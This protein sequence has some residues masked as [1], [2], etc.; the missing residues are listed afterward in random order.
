MKLFSSFFLSSSL[1][2]LGAG[3]AELKPSFDDSFSHPPEITITESGT[4][5][6]GLEGS[7]CFEG[8]CVDM[9]SPMEIMKEENRSFEDIGT[10]LITMNLKIIPTEISIDL[11]SDAMVPVCTMTSTKVTEKEYTTKLCTSNPGTYILTIGAWFA[12][13]DESYSF[14]IRMKE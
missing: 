8:T 14:P 6:H 1:I 4:V 3:C 13:G 2:L 9:I 7:F 12:G 10:A 11:F 5:H